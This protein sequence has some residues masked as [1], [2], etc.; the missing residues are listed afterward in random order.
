MESSEATDEDAPGTAIDFVLVQAQFAW[1]KA[2]QRLRRFAVEDTRTTWF[3]LLFTILLFSGTLMQ[4]MSAVNPL[5]LIEVEVLLFISILF[6]VLGHVFSN[7]W[8]K[9]VVCKLTI[10]AS[11]VL[12]SFILCVHAFFGIFDSASIL[13]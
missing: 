7:V 13:T 4:S 8:T 10:S 11:S 2:S 3:V 12:L 9:V 5:R 6:L 1:N